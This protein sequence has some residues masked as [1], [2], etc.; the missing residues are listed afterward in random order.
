MKFELFLLILGIG[1]LAIFSQM[2]MGDWTAST[3]P[4]ASLPAPEVSANPGSGGGFGQIEGLPIL[5]QFSASDFSIVDGDSIRLKANPAVAGGSQAIDLRLASVDAPELNQ[6]SG[7]AAKRH[8]QLLTAGR[9]ATF[10]QTDTDRYK[11]PVVFMFV[12]VPSAGTAGTMDVNA[13]M[14]ADGYAWHA[15]SF[16]SSE[17]LESLQQQA[18]MRRVGLWAEGNPVPPWEHRKRK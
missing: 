15:V 6:T 3:E 9:S 10:L 18:K 17:R 8:L 1:A 13:Q 2:P 7:Q 4:N 12:G 11:R 5:A 14:V 16:S